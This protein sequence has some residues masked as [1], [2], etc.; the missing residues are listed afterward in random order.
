MPLLDSL[1]AK[2]PDYPRALGIVYTEAGA[3]RL[4]AEII[5]RPEMSNGSNT[6]HGGAL[7]TFADTLGAVAT[8]INIPREKN[9]TTLE[10]KTNFIGRAPVGTRLIGTATPLHRGRT[11]QIWETLIRTEDGK[12]VA[13]VTQTQLVL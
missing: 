9:T 7:M 5:V 4:V 1:Q 3:D 10:S 8:I 2:L 6:I 12:L 11:T 13:K